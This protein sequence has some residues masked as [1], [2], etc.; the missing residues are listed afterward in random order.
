[1]LLLSFALKCLRYNISSELGMY[2]TDILPQFFP[3]HPGEESDQES[4]DGAEGQSLNDTL[5]VSP[6]SKKEDDSRQYN[7]KTSPC[8]SWLGYQ[9]NG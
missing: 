8:L 4:I 6:V 1:M 5:F 9:Q 3:V 7:K 2:K